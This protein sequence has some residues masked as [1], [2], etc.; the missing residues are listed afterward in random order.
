MS[1]GN[2]VRPLTMLIWMLAFA[3]FAVGLWKLTHLDHHSNDQKI[4]ID[5]TNSH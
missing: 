2:G 1:D 5:K 4:L 3:V